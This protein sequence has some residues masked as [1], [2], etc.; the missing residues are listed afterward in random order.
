MKHQFSYIIKR[1]LQE[2]PDK[3]MPLFKFID[4]LESRYHCTVSVSE[5]NKLRDICRITDEC[6]SRIISLSHELKTSPPPNFSKVI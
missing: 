2:V 1:L 6:G 3:C 4:L 5:V